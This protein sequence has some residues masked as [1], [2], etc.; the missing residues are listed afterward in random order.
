MLSLSRQRKPVL[1]LPRCARAEKPRRM[2]KY[3]NVNNDYSS[4]PSV[5]VGER[6]LN[7]ERRVHVVER[8]AVARTRAVESDSSIASACMSS[9]SSLGAGSAWGGTGR[10]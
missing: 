10:L 2:G 1:K 8:E 5:V 9:P 3:P 6:V 7:V 4:S